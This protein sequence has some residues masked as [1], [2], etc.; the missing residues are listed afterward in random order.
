[1]SFIIPALNE[2]AHL[3]LSIASIR[4]Q[5]LP[6][7]IEDVEILVVDTGST[8]STTQV[9]RQL[10]ARVLSA[11]SGATVAR[12]RNLGAGSSTGKLLAFIDA[13]CIPAPGLFEQAYRHLSNPCVVA[14]AGSVA[15]PPEDGTWVER[16][17][18][19]LGHRGNKTD[20]SEVDW[21]PTLNLFMRRDDFLAIGGFDETLA[22]CEDEDISRRLCRRGALIC[23]SRVRARHL[24]EPRTL[25]DFF[26]REV[27]RSRNNAKSYMTGDR[28]LRGLASILAPL[29]FLMAL[30]GIPVCG[31]LALFRMSTSLPL[32]GGAVGVCVAGPAAMVA[33]RGGSLRSPGDFLCGLVLATAYLVARALGMV[34]P[35]GRYPGRKGQ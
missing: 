30:A 19:W 2:A 28:Q 31:M 5:R 9:A 29:V 1:V 4:N 3:P 15:P 20:F 14:V 6:E 22:T 10:G 13:D 23:E 18:F 12:A 7:G 17:W 25:G 32:L 26:R 24:G 27:W 34:L 35:S 33:R 16:T 21:L 8:D 11:G